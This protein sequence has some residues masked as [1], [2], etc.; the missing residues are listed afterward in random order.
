MQNCCG[1]YDEFPGETLLRKEAYVLMH[2]QNNYP[3]TSSRHYLEKK[4]IIA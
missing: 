2:T 1:I 3:V 4:L